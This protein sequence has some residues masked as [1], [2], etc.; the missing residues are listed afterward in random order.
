MM[1]VWIAMSLGTAIHAQKNGK[2]EVFW[3]VVVAISGIL[4]MV[5]Y[6]ISLAS[7]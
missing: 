5:A 4:G 1:V 6:A 7:D 3:F 2:G